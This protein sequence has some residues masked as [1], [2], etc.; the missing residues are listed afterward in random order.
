MIQLRYYIIL[1]PIS[2][3]VREAMILLLGRDDVRLL[4][5]LPACIDAV[6][7]SFRRHALGETIPPGVL[8]AHVDG[9]GFHVKTAGLRGQSGAPARFAAKVNAN[10]PGNRDRHGLPTIQGVIALFDATDGRVLALLDT[11]EV[12]TLRTAAATALAARHL[13]RED[14]GLVTVC[15]CGEQGRGQLRALECVRPVRRAFAYDE[16]VVRAESFATSM[17]AELGIDVRPVRELGKATA[18]SDIWVTCTTARRW[19]LGRSHV[20]RGTFVA[21][22][23]ADHPEKQEIEPGLLAASVVIADVL[24]QCVA[25]G[26][27]HHALDAGVMRRGDVRGEL[28]D[29]VSGRVIGRQSAD[30]IIVFDSTGTA[31][32]DVAAASVVYDRAVASGVGLHVD[33]ARGSESWMPSRVSE[34]ET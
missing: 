26:D 1:P 4:L 34:V 12:T 6:D 28:A 31:L 14:A 25:M 13:A 24:D 10:F 8:G 21:A 20:R 16:N 15:G 17:S 22:V 5:D 30:E 27:L 2:T 11:M 19:F 33:L 29:V 3:P 7:D 9:G 32:Q 23:G 18:E